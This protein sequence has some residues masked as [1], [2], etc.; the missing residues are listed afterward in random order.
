M[1]RQR[2]LSGVL[3]LILALGW[4][5]VA[6][7]AQSP[8]RGGTLTIGNDED[9]VG[10][11]PHLS[12]AFASS[13]YYEHVYNGLLRFN[14]RME[15]EGD[16]AASWEVPDPR[17]YVFKLRKGVRFHNGRELTAEDVKYS[18][19][20][21]RDPKNGSVV[22]SVYAAVERVETPDAHT[23]VLK[24]NRPNAA[25]IGMLATR[26]SH[27]VPKEEVDR[28]GT[29][30]KVAVG[31]GPFKLVEHVAGSHTRFV[32]ND[33]YF[34]AGLPYLDGFT[35]QVI[36]DESSRLAALR[37]GTVD[38]TWIKATEVEEL[39]RRE[40]GIVSADTP[41]ARH[42]YVWLNTR[43]PPFNNVKVR[44]A[45]AAS[46][47]R[48]EIIDTVLLGRGKLTTAIPP[49]TV[50][51][52]LGP[53]EIAAL[54]FYKADVAQAKKLLAEAGHPGGV[55]FTLKT[56]SHSPD[57][58]PAAQVMQRQL[59]PAGIRLKIEQMEW[60][61]LLNLARTGGEFHAIAFA[62][63]W[64]PD[65]EGYT[66]DTLHGKGSFNVGGYSNPDSDRLLEEQRATVDVGKRVALWKDLQ[67]L[68]AQ[69]VPIV[70]PYAM[71]TRF[72]A[73]RPHVK[74]FQAMA[75]SSRIYLR[76]AWIER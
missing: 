18:I 44:Q 26:A 37:K 17:T 72:N 63:I 40:K 46:L 34:E 38:V 59:A 67:R 51:F 21:I 50:P 12:V 30:Q 16:L 10:L 15:L 41:E 4:L 31:T 6:A 24:L 19:D 48:Q 64:Y 39:A 45:V 2:M 1:W 66:Y 3:G 55:E 42:L 36:K 76:E 29:L 32:R 35:I 22:R 56:S 68:W 23:V 20:R 5:A 7:E 70:W 61:A 62:R 73:W 53:A 74:G 57:Y 28:H 52:V 49:A 14:A 25:L 71:R 60:G 33:Q 65:P 58:V 75:N 13:N 43:Q 9:S 69:D 8:R 11:D 27:V 54:P 47:N